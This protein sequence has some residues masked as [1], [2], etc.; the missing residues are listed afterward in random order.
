MNR[1]ASTLAALALALVA[2]GE[3]VAPVTRPVR[4]RVLAWDSALIPVADAVARAE[5]SNGLVIEQRATADGVVELALDV[6]ARWDVTLAGPTV[7]P[8]SILAL[9][10]REASSP[11]D[12]ALTQRPE[13]LQQVAAPSRP[14]AVFPRN[15][16]VHRLTVH[17][18]NWRATAGAGMLS[19]RGRFISEATSEQFVPEPSATYTATYHFAAFAQAP[20]I[21]LWLGEGVA[22]VA[23]QARTQPTRG[24]LVQVPRPAQDVEVDLDFADAV[25]APAAVTARV[26]WSR[27]GVF[28]GTTVQPRSLPQI[29][30]V[31]SAWSDA[32]YAR[33]PV[34]ELAA[35]EPDTDTTIP[36][37][38]T[39]ASD[40]W[41]LDDDL[42]RF[43]Y[44]ALSFGLVRPDGGRWAVDIAAD[45]RASGEI[46]LPSIQELSA[47]ANGAAI[48]A[49]LVVRSDAAQAGFVVTTAESPPSELWRGWLWGS[50]SSAAARRFRVPRLPSGISLR[51]LAGG[52]SVQVSAIVSTLTAA[53]PGYGPHQRAAERVQVGANTP[54][55]SPADSSP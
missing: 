43:V 38:I 7:F 24:V 42:G 21:E 5:S 6:E 12:V 20:P 50:P 28:D 52:S 36:L 29:R 23:P 39:L 40:R 45:P 31:L 19:F 41:T 3:R 46:E 25:A 11:I 13:A 9:E 48:G 37:R 17:V 26:R 15:A 51:S 18:R 22:S 54:A 14:A 4:F 35:F 44:G 53:A 47:S 30:S 55:L 49:E 27:S 33:A 16:T 1:V 2:C 8:L 34:G 10:P 32:P